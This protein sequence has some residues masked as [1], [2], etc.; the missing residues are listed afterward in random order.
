MYLDR[1]SLLLYSHDI[2]RYLIIIVLCPSM[3]VRSSVP[4]DIIGEYTLELSLLL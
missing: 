4:S 2:V 3:I 1:L